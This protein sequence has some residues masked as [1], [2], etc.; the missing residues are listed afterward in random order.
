MG[1]Q[2]VGTSSGRNG[3]RSIVLAVSHFLVEMSV[4][5][6]SEL[7]DDDM[8]KSLGVLTINAFDV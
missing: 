1:I 7:F 3:G 4:R 5:S 2:A 6:R 8:I